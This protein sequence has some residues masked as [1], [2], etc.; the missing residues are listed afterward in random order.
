MK[1]YMNNINKYYGNMTNYTNTTG[2]QETKGK[3]SKNFDELMI[4][5][6]PRQI[7]ERTMV[8]SMAKAVSSE[9]HKT[10]TEEKINELREKITEGTYT[11]DVSA[12]A[13]KILFG[14]NG[15]E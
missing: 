15:D 7:K 14:R 8:E 1:V 6:S 9:V 10:T 5:S 11:V 3:K 2:T 13:S 4:Q 12:I